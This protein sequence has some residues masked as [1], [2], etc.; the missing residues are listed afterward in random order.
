MYLIYAV[1]N[2]ASHARKASFAE[3]VITRLFLECSWKPSFICGGLNAPS[4][5]EKWIKTNEFNLED[6]EHGKPSEKLGDEELEASLD[7]D[8][9]QTDCH[10]ERLNKPFQN[11]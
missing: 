6:K 2:V 7:E 1:K 9:C 5:C 3:S 11:F 10:W 8:P 4:M